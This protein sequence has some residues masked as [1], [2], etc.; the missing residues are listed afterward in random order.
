AVEP[1]VA[2]RGLKERATRTYS[3]LEGIFEA[4]AENRVKAGYVI[5]TRGHWLAHERWPGKLKFIDG[6]AADRFPICAAVR[7]SDKDLKAAIDH[8]FAEL[9]ESEKLAAAFARWKIPRK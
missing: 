1:G 8:V 7:K 4:I 2:A 9:A 5:S 3:S 6:D